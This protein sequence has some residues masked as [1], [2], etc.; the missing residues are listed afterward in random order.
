MG[1]FNSESCLFILKVLTMVRNFVYF[2]CSSKSLEAQPRVHGAPVG[3]P[4]GAGL[5]LPDGEWRGWRERAGRRGGLAGV[6]ACVSDH[7]RVPARQHRPA[8]VTDDAGCTSS[9]ARAEATGPPLMGLPGHFRTASSE[10]PGRRAER[11]SGPPLAEEATSILVLASGTENRSVRTEPSSTPQG[12]RGCRPEGLR[13]SPRNP[14]ELQL[15][16]AQ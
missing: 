6:R 12:P 13:H 9:G 15:R 1:C 16:S 11:R 5:P 10:T 8:T 14:D 3:V 7:E 2:K 4:L